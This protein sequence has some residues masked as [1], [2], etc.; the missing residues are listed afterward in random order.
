MRTFSVSTLAPVKGRRGS[1][2]LEDTGRLVSTHAP[3]EGATLQ[4][5]TL[6]RHPAVS[7]HAPVKGRPQSL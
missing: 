5:D 2:G 7:T 6:T 1:V 4:H 3:C